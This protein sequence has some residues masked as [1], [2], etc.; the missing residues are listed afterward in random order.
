MRSSRHRRYQLDVGIRSCGGLHHFAGFGR[1]DALLVVGANVPYPRESRWASPLRGR[2]GGCAEA[3]HCGSSPS[4]A[5]IPDARSCELANSHDCGLDLADL[6]TQPHA[7]AVRAR[8][9]R[10][11][12]RACHFHPPASSLQP[13]P[14]SFRR[15]GSENTTRVLASQDGMDPRMNDVRFGKTRLRER[16]NPA[17]EWAFLG[18]RAAFHDQPARGSLRKRATSSASPAR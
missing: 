2:A 8:A 10:P 18:S 7:P 14:N 11:F 16:T 13:S 17:L 5:A 3:P 9:Q 4:R 1:Q 12:H 15:L 6:E